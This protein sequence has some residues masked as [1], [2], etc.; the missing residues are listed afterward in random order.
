MSEDLNENT[1]PT[2]GSNTQDM[3]S[4]IHH[5]MHSII[6]KV[7]I[8]SSVIVIALLVVIIMMLNRPQPSMMNNIS[9]SIATPKV[10]VDAVLPSASVDA[11]TR[12]FSNTTTIV[13]FLKK[14]AIVEL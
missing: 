14:L 9:D 2:A 4:D 1:E 12:C 11:S 10:S 8:G 5:K 13:N 6:L 7:I 3:I